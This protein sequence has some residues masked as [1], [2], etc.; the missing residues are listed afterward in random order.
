[1][2]YSKKILIDELLEECRQLAE[3]KKK[4]VRTCEKAREYNL[5]RGQQAIDVTTGAINEI[6]SELNALKGVI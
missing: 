6:I 5:S 3:Q 4:I 1:M 2:G